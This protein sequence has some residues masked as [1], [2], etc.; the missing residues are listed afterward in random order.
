MCKICIENKDNKCVGNLAMGR[1]RKDEKT[2]KVSVRLE[3]EGQLRE[4][5]LTLMKSRGATTYK[6][7]CHI[8]ITEAYQ[9][10]EEKEK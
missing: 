2:G 3:L 7:L 9:E 4:K 8:L 6:D 1:K 5:F 10:L